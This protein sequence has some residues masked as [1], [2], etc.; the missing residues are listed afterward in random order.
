MENK[1]KKWKINDKSKISIWT[2]WKYLTALKTLKPTYQKLTVTGAIPEDLLS[3]GAE[4][5]I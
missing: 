4:E 3:K 1:Q 5:E 2:A